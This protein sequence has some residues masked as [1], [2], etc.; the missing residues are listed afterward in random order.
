MADIKSYQ[1]SKNIILNAEVPAQSRTYK[2]ISN[3]QLID[4]TIEGISN[5]GFE[6][7]KEYYSSAREGNVA[8]GKYTIKGVEDNE[9]QLQLLWRNSYNKSLP[10][11]FNVSCMIK[12]CSNGMLKPQGLGSFKKK[13]LGE[14]QTFTPYAISEY[15]K[16]AQDTFEQM[17]KE[18]EQMKQI[19]L[20]RNIQAKICGEMFVEHE[21]LKS[22]Q[23][24][25]VKRE[26]DCPTHDYGD[27]MSLWSMF[28]YSTYAMREIHPSLYLQD[29]IDAYKFYTQQA[30]IILSA[31]K[32]LILPEPESPF[33]QLELFDEL[34]TTSV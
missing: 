28:N 32:E 16:N 31:P 11:S 24:N 29:H 23:L 10:V 27:P 13:H 26:L 14:V 17:Q 33:V 1:V 19:E 15:I 34:F 2:P 4:L 30:G 8:I 7:D 22:T 9:M 3:R 5:S 18:R 21:F 25:I 20:T 12:V 6:L